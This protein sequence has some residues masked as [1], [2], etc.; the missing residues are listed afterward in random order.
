VGHFPNSA[1]HAL[2]ATPLTLQVV[3]YVV[4]FKAAAWVGAARGTDRAIPQQ[5]IPGKR[6]AQT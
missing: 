6:Y 2:P 1:G 3:L 5:N 4:A